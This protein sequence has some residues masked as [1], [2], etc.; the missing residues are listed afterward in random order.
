MNNMCTVPYVILFTF[1]LEIMSCHLQAKLFYN[2]VVFDV[3]DTLT[4]H[5]QLKRV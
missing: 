5:L 4:F 1:S 2:F 3:H